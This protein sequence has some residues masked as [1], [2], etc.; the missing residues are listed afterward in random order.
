MHEVAEAAYGDAPVC[1]GFALSVLQGRPG[2]VVWVVQDRSWRTHG[3]PCGAGLLAQ[4]F[5]PGRLILVEA[6]KTI[7]ALWAAE[8]AVRSGAAG[9]VVAEVEDADF[10]QTRRLSLVA[11]ATGTPLILLLPYGREGATAAQARWRVSARPSAPN[12][13]D[14]RAPGASRWRAVLERSRAAPAQVGRIFDLEYDDETLSLR[15]VSE[16]AAGP[17][18]TH[19]ISDAHRTSDTDLKE[20]SC[21]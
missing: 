11:E 15:L 13:F 8:E 14:P 9:A 1:A 5:D 16:L 18:A 2:A 10:T 19:P 7:D 21:A 12:R 17:V 4:G 3:A 6:R 20:A